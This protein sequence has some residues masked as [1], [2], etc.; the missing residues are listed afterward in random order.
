MAEREGNGAGLIAKDVAIVRQPKELPTGD[1]GLSDLLLRVE[2]SLI[3]SSIPDPANQSSRLGPLDILARGSDFYLKF[4]SSSDPDISAK[5]AEYRSGVSYRDGQPGIFDPTIEIAKLTRA[6]YGFR[7]NFPPVDS[8]KG[9]DA[10]S[11]YEV[12]LTRMIK[13]GTTDAPPSY[14]VLED[15][16]LPDDVEDA[17]ISVSLHKLYEDAFHMVPKKNGNGKIRSFEITLSNQD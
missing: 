7:M 16:A 5:R 15:E 13:E 10:D 6:G 1:R 14:E 3:G 4:S 8:T 2:H 11:V 17:L 9:G 12:Q